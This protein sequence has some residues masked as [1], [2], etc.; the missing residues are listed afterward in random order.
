MLTCPVYSKLGVLKHL[1]CVI[2]VTGRYFQ[3]AIGTD[4]QIYTQVVQR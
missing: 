4:P 2:F 1:I 3:Q